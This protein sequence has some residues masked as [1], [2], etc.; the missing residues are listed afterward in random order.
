MCASSCRTQDHK[1]FGECIRSQG[2]MI[3][4]CNSAS[5]HDY[6]NQKRA[7]RD[8]DAYAA[9]VKSGIQPANTSRQ[10]TNDAVILSDLSGSAFQA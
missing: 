7:D 3:A 6:T 5:G 8:L 9:A 10:A 2:Q 4:Y 1:T